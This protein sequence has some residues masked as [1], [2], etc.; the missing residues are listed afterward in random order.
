MFTPPLLPLQHF[1]C[2]PFPLD[3]TEFHT[4]AHILTERPI[5]IGLHS[6]GSFTMKV[7]SAMCA[8]TEKLQYVAQLSPDSQNYTCN[9]KYGMDF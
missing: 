8:Q 5:Y 2:D 1:S 7:M 9:N 4:L 6:L 3:S